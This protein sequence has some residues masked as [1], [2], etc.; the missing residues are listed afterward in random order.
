[1]TQETKTILIIAAHPDD[2]EAGCGG[3]A[4]KWTAEGYRVVLCVATNGDKGSDDPTMTSDKLVAL[5]DTEQREAAR[6][7]GIEDVVILPNGDGELNDS[8][9]FRGQLVRLIRKYRPTRVVTHNPY[10]WQ[11]RDHRV[12]GQVTLDAVYPYA[13]DRLHYSELQQE[14]LAPHKTAEVYLWAGFNDDREWDVEEDVTEYLPAKLD[15]LACHVSQ[16]GPPEEAR[17]RWGPRWD[18]LKEQRGGRLTERFKRV[19]FSV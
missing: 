3:S 19:E 1:M 2:C 17:A 8:R 10:H 4:A 5:R 7:L 11:H 15:A 14:G 13:R 18:R 9:E 16:F 6:H 12:T